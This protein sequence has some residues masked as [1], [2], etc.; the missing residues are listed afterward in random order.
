MDQSRSE[1]WPEPLREHIDKLQTGNGES[2]KKYS[3]RLV[4]SAVADVHRTVVGSV[5]FMKYP[6]ESA[7]HRWWEDL[8]AVSRMYWQNVTRSDPTPGNGLCRNIADCGLDRSGSFFRSK[9][10]PT[11]IMAPASPPS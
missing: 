2:G 3:Y 11:Y 9:R 1:S 5:A 4:G 8:T 10:D 7:C 6:Y